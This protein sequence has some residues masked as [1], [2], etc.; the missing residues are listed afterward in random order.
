M[1]DAFPGEP[2]SP[3]LAPDAS[4]TRA[5][6]VKYLLPAAAADGLQDW[7]RASLA[8]DPHADPALQGAYEITTLYLDT[9]RFDVFHR[10]RELDET[11]YRLRRYGEGSLVYLERKRRR[12]DRVTKRR[13]PVAAGE[14]GRLGAAGDDW[15]GAWFRGE[16]G[17]RGFRPVCGLTYLRTAF[18]GAGETGPFR[19]TFDRG[20]RGVP[21]AEWSLGRVEGEATRIAEG[22]TIV[23][24]KFRE[25]LPEVLKR[26]IAKLEMRPSGLSKYR[27]ACRA[28]RIVPGKAEDACLTG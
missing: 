12:K 16:I 9:P 23:E 4:T 15:A 20:I 24:M 27:A 17:A 11:K 8:A 2:V 18:F 10:A 25:A 3:S 19:L 22:L 1:L 28:A 14:L 6:E 7:A 21:R 26:V 13:T 5:Y